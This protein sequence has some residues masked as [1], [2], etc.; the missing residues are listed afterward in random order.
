[1]AWNPSKEVAVARDAA[2]RLDADMCV[3]IFVNAHKEQIG[4]AS[5]GSNA[6]LCAETKK[7]ADC[8]YE[9]ARRWFE[10]P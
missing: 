8:C 7:L 3:V 2:Q 9:A 4:Y 6:P 10:Q 1:M 5:Y